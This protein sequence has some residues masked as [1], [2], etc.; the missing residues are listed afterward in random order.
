[1]K[2]KKIIIALLILI[3]VM[4]AFS[5]CGGRAEEDNQGGGSDEKYVLDLSIHVALGTL[6]GKLYEQFAADVFDA[7]DGR[8]EII[9][10]PASE[11]PYDTTEYL[12]VCGQGLIDMVGAQSGYVAGDSKLA[13]LTSMPFLCAS[14]DEFIEANNVLLPELQAEFGK[15]NTTLLFYWL[16]SPQRFWGKG[17]AIKDWGDM[18]GLKLRTYSPEQ[19][20]FAAQVGAVPVSMA[21]SEVPSSVQ[22]GVINSLITG[23]VWANDNKYYDF[24]DWAFP[25]PFNMSGIWVLINNDV[26]KKL[27]EEVK[28]IFIDQCTLAQDSFITTIKNTDSE[29]MQ[30]MED[31]GVVFSEIP[32]EII[33]SGSSFML[34]YW[35]EWAHTNSLE[36]EMKKVRDL[37]G[38]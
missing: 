17:K 8:L 26:L 18:K 19:Q 32:P 7:T 12:K 10:R 22:R 14:M 33:E 38:R 35:V 25:V 31:N 13:T 21:A 27:P 20:H 2:N 6:Y 5:G 1:M 30:S 29:A 23:A 3:L 28:N 4:T 24:V 9:V 16:D 11:L 37:L 36:A 34:D 15:F